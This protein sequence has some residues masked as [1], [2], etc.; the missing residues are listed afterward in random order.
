MCCGRYSRHFRER[1]SHKSAPRN[2]GVANSYHTAAEVIVTNVTAEEFL[3]RVPVLDTNRRVLF[4]QRL[5]AREFAR[6]MV[7]RKNKS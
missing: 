2:R 5:R 3:P 6:A 1:G 7:L 4:A